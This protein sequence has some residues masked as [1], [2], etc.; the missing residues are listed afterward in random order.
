[1]ILLPPQHVKQFMLAGDAY[2]T[3]KNERTGNFMHFHVLLSKN[4]TRYF[5]EVKKGSVVETEGG[6]K[7]GNW[8]YMGE[9][10]DGVLVL[11]PKS[12]VD[13]E[14]TE[15]RSFN[16]LLRKIQNGTWQDGVVIY[17]HVWCGRC[18]RH[19]M[20]EVSVE[21]GLGAHC[22]Y[23]ITGKRRSTAGRRKKKSPASLVD[24]AQGMVVAVSGNGGSNIPPGVPEEDRDGE[25]EPYFNP[26]L[27]PGV[28]A[29]M[30]ATM[31][32]PGDEAQRVWDEMEREAGK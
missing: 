25:D 8:V 15:F 6:E 27:I 26:M 31:G 5:V 22:Y 16:W 28:A 32:L 23:K 20:D 29:R 9:I 13:G 19:L 17:R 1:M 21:D 14:S 4:K 24:N 7:D 10:K 12:R 18:G 11:T 2:F 30:I 3:M